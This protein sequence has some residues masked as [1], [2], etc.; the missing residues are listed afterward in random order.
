MSYHRS[1]LGLAWRIIINLAPLSRAHR[2]ASSAAQRRAVPRGAV[3]CRVLPVPCR[4]VRYCC[5]V[6]CHAVPCC[7]LFAVLFTCQVSFEVPY[8][9]H[10]CCTYQVL[11]AE[12]QK[13]IHYSSAQPS[14][15]SAAQR[16]APC[17][18]VRCRALPFGAVP[19]CAVLSFEHTTEPGAM[20]YP[21]PTGACACVRVF[22]SLSS[23][24]CPLSVLLFFR[25][26]THTGDQN[27]ASPTSTHS[28]A[29]GNQ[30]CV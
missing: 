30:L 25:N 29:Q 8:H 18:A 9:R 3:P 15:S 21:V 27:V 1:H 24:D 6:L 4:A 7:V 23:F 22:F 17:G 11:Y 12:S 20:R 26:Y 19:C 14:D 10:Y 5:A 28:T 13:N 2:S 16:S